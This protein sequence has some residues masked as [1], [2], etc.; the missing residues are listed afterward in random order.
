MKLTNNISIL[1]ANKGKSI[2]VLSSRFLIASIIV[3]GLSSP[4]HGLELIDENIAGNQGAGS[5]TLILRTK[6]DL[7]EVQAAWNES[8]ARDNVLIVQHDK[9]VTHKLRLREMMNTLIVLPYG[10]KIEAV[11]LGDKSNF[12]F[13][14]V[15]NDSGV[16]FDNMGN[17]RAIYPGADTNLSLITSDGNIYSF[18]LRVDTVKSYFMPDLIVYVESE[19]IKAKHLLEK[20]Q[21]IEAVKKAEDDKKAQVLATQYSSNPKDGEYLKTR[22]DTNAADLNFNYKQKSGDESLMPV[23]I[24]DDGLWT[25]FQY[26]DDNLD[27]VKNLPAIYRVVDG[28]DTPVNSRIEGGTIVVETTSDKWTLR[29]GNAHACVRKEI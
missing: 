29:S 20:K 28:F 5:D 25:Y 24:M 2:N 15:R 17:I 13:E 12:V 16:S 8:D 11:S 6:L 21:K 18:Y 27:R 7:Q 1:K 23:R 14:P 9:H 3:L 22:S 10:E 26:A 19:T 4:A